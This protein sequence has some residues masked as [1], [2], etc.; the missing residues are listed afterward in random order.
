MEQDPAAATNPSEMTGQKSNASRSDS[1]I[2]LH[3][4]LWIVLQDIDAAKKESASPQYKYRIGHVQAETLENLCQSY[5]LQRTHSSGIELQSFTGETLRKSLSNAWAGLVKDT[6]SRRDEI[7]HEGSSCCKEEKLEQY[8]AAYDK[9]SLEHDLPRYPDVRQSATLD[10]SVLASAPAALAG[11][12]SAGMD[13]DAGA[14]VI[15]SNH[16]D[17]SIGAKKKMKKKTKTNLHSKRKANQRRTLTKDTLNCL[18]CVKRKKKCNRS[19][20]CDSCAN[21]NS[22]YIYSAGAGLSSNQTIPTPAIHVNNES[23]R[24]P[25]KT[26]GSVLSTTESLT[27]EDSDCTPLWQ[28]SHKR[29]HDSIMASEREHESD[30]STL[31]KSSITTPHQISRPAT[32]ETAVVPTAMLAEGQKRRTQRSS[33]KIWTRDDADSAMSDLY[34][35]LRDAVVEYLDARK[36]IGRNPATPPPNPLLKVLYQRCWSDNW[37]SLCT[38][39]LH[40]DRRSVLNDTMALISAFIFDIILTQKLPQEIVSLCQSGSEPAHAENLTSEFA[41]TFT[42]YFSALDHSLGL[43]YPEPLTV[44]DSR[45]EPSIL[46]IVKKALRLKAGLEQCGSELDFV[47]PEPYERFEPARMRVDVANYS[48]SIASVAHTVF[49]GLLL[50]YLDGNRLVTEPPCKARVVLQYNVRSH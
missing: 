22:E 41:L 50:S 30:T 3:R 10:L 7:W 45:L 16:A 12:A 1:K 14:N 37:P 46:E 29:K 11:V 48:T 6:T 49:P 18:K 38:K 24:D 13:R 20:P 43:M 8:Q 31:R 2:H 21:L 4:A 32:K 27:N 40:E 47:W 36:L 15:G 5:T 17:G 25:K 23:S 34:N 9:L 42:Q 33:A 26:K 44:D 28:A 39:L 19:K 35:F